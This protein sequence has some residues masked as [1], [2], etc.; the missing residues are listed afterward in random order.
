MI[1]YRQAAIAIVLLVATA[2]CRE[3]EQFL[4]QNFEANFATLEKIRVMSDQ[5]PRVIRIAPTFTRLDT[6][7]SWPRPRDKWGITEERWNEYRKL[8]RAANIETGL[9]RN[10]GTL[11]LTI[12]ACGLSVSG[13]SR[14]Y[15]YSPNP[16]QPLVQH[17]AEYHAPKGMAFV[18][19][20]NNWYLFVWYF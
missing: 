19:L 13:V 12:Q 17:L 4:R 20:R 1:I 16:P 2:C 6:D 3:R 9:D 18:P 5:D 7:W 15:F 10:E 11:T 8:F 14:G